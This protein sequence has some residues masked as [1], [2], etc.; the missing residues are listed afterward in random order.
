MAGSFEQEPNPDSRV[1]LAEESDELGMPLA[2]IHWALTPKTLQTAIRFSELIDDAL[3]RH[4]LG[5][6]SRPEWLEGTTVNYEEHFHD[7]NHHMGTARMSNFSEE[8]RGRFESPGSFNPEPLR[9]LKCCLPNW[10]PLQPYLDP[11]C[12]N[13][14]VSRPFES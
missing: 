6:L 5:G 12:P 1:S 11:T 3:V 4:G 2:K 10:R 13:H 9:R 7:Q 14:P 8:W